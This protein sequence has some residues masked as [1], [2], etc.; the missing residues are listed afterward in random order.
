M[1]QP[2]PTV[3]FFLGN[4]GISCKFCHRLGS[5]LGEPFWLDGGWL[6]GMV[7]WLDMRCDVLRP[8]TLPAPPPAAAPQPAPQPAPH[9][10][11]CGRPSRRPRC[12]RRTSRR[13]RRSR[14][15]AAPP[16]AP[17]TAPAA[18]PTILRRSRTIDLLCALLPICHWDE[19]YSE[20]TGSEIAA[21]EDRT[22]LGHNGFL[23]GCLIQCKVLVAPEM[24]RGELRRSQCVILF[25]Y[26]SV[27]E[28]QPCQCPTS[29]WK[30]T[31]SRIDMVLWVSNKLMQ[32]GLLKAAKLIWGTCTRSTATSEPSLPK[33]AACTGAPSRVRGI[34]RRIVA[35]T[36]QARHS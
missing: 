11:R 24:T 20:P 35:D 12:R 31:T 14:N 5:A 30:N 6:D 18:V 36:P 19:L 29:S 16:E 25:A 9:A 27:P 8:Q 21:A 1:S 2:L 22:T 4:R 28:A 26:H 10:S 3:V 7:G 17:E 32:Q 13:R 23:N 15:A 34:G 33:D